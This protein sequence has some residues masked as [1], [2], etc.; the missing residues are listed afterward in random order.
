VSEEAK[1]LA[2]LSGQP[3]PMGCLAISEGHKFVLDTNINQKVIHR[4][5]DYD[6][7]GEDLTLNF[8]TD[9][10]LKGKVRDDG[11]IELVGL[12]FVHKVA[13][14]SVVGIWKVK[15]VDARMEFCTDGT[16]KFKC[17]GAKS[18]GTY[19]FDGSAIVLTWTSIDGEAVDPDTMH[20]TLL[21]DDQGTFF[22]DNYH[23]AKE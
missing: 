9:L 22:I 18:A 3:A 21:V 15:N 1:G 11:L 10:H 17:T 14:G 23:Y 12:K 19:K 20:K 4:T 8:G 2:L 5:G 16:F 13:T 7:D 6:I